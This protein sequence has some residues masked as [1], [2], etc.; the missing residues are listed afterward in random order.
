MCEIQNVSRTDLRLVSV[1]TDSLNLVEI[2]TYM[3]NLPA[4]PAGHTHFT[5]FLTE[6]TDF[7]IKLSIVAVVYHYCSCVLSQFLYTVT[8]V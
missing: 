3:L 1:V 7:N 4:I 6:H 5:K 2:H 8:C